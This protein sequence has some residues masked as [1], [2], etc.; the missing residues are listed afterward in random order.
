MILT[1]KLKLAEES[2]KGADSMVKMEM[3]QLKNDNELLQA[4]NE[5]KDQKL[6]KLGDEMEDIKIELE[7]S[8]K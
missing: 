2:G 4:E 1:Q 8:S 3:A 7:K 6:D 5:E